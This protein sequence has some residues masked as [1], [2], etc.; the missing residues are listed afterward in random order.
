M[1]WYDP[2]EK[3]WHDPPPPQP[4]KPKPEPPENI[5]NIA[6]RNNFAQRCWEAT[7][8]AAQA[9]RMQTKAPR[10]D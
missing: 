7:Q 10:H 6:D 2:I 1:R 4:P 3:K 8:A 9:S 5:Y